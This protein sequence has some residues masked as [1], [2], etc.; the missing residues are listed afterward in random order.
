MGFWLSGQLTSGPIAWVIAECIAL[1]VGVCVSSAGCLTALE[2]Y[3]SPL[4]TRCVFG[5]SVEGLLTRQ[6]S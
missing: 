1:V 5:V 2:G 4:I 3:T 6:V